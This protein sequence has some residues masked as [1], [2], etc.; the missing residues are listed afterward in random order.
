MS[1][2]NIDDLDDIISSGSEKDEQVNMISHKTDNVS[3][4]I[5]LHKISNLAKLRGSEDTPLPS[6]KES[7][8]DSESEQKQMSD[9]SDRKRARR[10][11]SSV[12]QI[13]TEE[14]TKTPVEI[15][16]E[17]I[18]YLQKLRGLQ[19]KKVKLTKDYNMSDNV[20]EMRC[21]YES[22]KNEKDAK[23]ALILSRQILITCINL[24]EFGNKNYSPFQLHLDG[25]AESVNE[26]LD[27]YDDIFLELH[28]KYK[29]DV[30]M[31]PEVKLILMLVT[32]AISHH[33]SQ[34][35]CQRITKMSGGKSGSVGGSNMAGLGNLMS[36]MN[37]MNN[38]QQSATATET[39]QQQDMTP[40]T[41]V[42]DILRSVQNQMSES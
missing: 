16:K 17:K 30:Q 8:D 11:R 26:N 25:W 31:G 20:E 27:M 36:M 3:T 14:R 15:E 19:R 7:S 18:E 28:E 33:V 22:V 13:Q 40:P 35:F 38:K 29:A 21:E 39:P 41:G 2:E 34:L 5:G 37:S 4:T 1:D 12:T 24:L 42:D 23:N 10:N 9:S 32:G 6:I